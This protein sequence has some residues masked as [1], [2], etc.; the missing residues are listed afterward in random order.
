LLAGEVS[1]GICTPL[2][3]FFS[4]KLDSKYGKRKIWYYI[5]FAIS[6]PIFGF[7]FMPPSFVTQFK[8]DGVT[9]LDANFRKY[10]FFACCF[11][12]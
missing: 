9:P 5:G 3:G 10:Y 2:V 7:I 4:D 6:F 11:M 1:D 8:E 12:F